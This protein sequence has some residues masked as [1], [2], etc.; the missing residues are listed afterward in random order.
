RSPLPGEA[1]TPAA[2]LIPGKDFPANVADNDGRFAREPIDWSWAPGAEA[3][4]LGT[5]AQQPNPDLRDL[6][7]HCRS[8]LCRLE[9]LVSNPT[10]PQTLNGNFKPFE[11][12]AAFIGFV[13]DPAGAV[14]LVMYFPRAD[15]P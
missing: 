9:A 7:V 4:L 11:I 13:T 15:H 8:T 12:N 1:P 10:S 5:F 3:E 6:R 14:S 2:F